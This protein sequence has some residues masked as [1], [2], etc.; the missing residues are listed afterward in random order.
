M[1]EHAVHAGVAHDPHQMQP[2]AR[3]RLHA[4][5][6]CPPHRIGRELLLEKQLVQPH[7][8]L[9]DD[10]AGADV[11]VTDLAVAHHPGGQPHIEARCPD[12]GMWIR[13]M[14]PIVARFL[15][16]GDRVGLVQRGIGI[17]APAITDDEEDGR[18]L[19]HKN[20]RFGFSGRS[21]RTNFRNFVAPCFPI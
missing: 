14:E 13:G 2:R 12:Q 18:F 10:P 4:R 1:L 21:G 8:F 3:P 16:E 6:A 17:L 15:R 19:F 20:L 11:L 7:E 9:V 5:D